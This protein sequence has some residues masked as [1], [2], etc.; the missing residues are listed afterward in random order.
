[1]PPLRISTIPSSTRVLTLDPLINDGALWSKVNMRRVM[2]RYPQGL[3]FTNK[4]GVSGNVVG[5][6][7]AW[8]VYGNDHF[9]PDFSREI[10]DAFARLQYPGWK[11]AK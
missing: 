5:R 9:M 11:I 3:S 7:V 10:L 2:A 1:M 8:S 6:D 4:P